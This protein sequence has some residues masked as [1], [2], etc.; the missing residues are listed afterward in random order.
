MTT[1]TN[2]VLQSLGMRTQQQLQ[3]AQQQAPQTL[4]QSEFL[5]LMITQL[6]NQDPTKPMDSNQM[7]SQMA[8][9]SQVTGLQQ[10]QKSFATLSS[11]LSSNQALQASNLV[12]HHVL[13]PT[14]A[15]LLSSG[16]D[17]SGAVNLSSAASNV[18]VQIQ[19]Q[20][21]Q[22]VRTLHLGTQAAG[23]ANFTWNGLDD[24]GQPAAPGKYS[25]TASATYGGKE[26]AV[27]TW[28]S[29]DVQ[30]VTINKSGSLSL[31]LAGLGPIDFSKV[32]QIM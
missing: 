28:T 8:Q 16:G 20:S 5:K 7:I 15:G 2:S 21:G 9:F 24:N 4:G 26:Q 29:A 19:D 14:G 1:S 11:S 18:T 25:I 6:K 30:S 3:Q 22:L 32:R 10:L 23:P 17:I 27:D 31:N 12:G 13:A